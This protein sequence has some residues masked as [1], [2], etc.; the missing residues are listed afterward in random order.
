MCLD[1]PSSGKEWLG[2]ELECPSKKVITKQGRK[3]ADLEH[4]IQQIRDWRAWVTDNLSYARQ[5]KEQNGLGLI[6]ITPRFFGHVIIGR[7]KDYNNKFNELRRQLMRDELITIHS[8]DGFVEYARKRASVFSTISDL[9][10]LIQKQQELIEK[11]KEINRLKEL[12]TEIKHAEELISEN[13]K[14]ISILEQQYHQGLVEF[15]TTLPESLVGKISTLL[16]TDSTV[17]SIIKQVED[18]IPNELPQ[19]LLADYISRIMTKS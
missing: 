1:I 12:V 18:E 13:D 14:T 3:T 2:I 16:K 17:S 19:S 8:W 11:S 4:A 15:G 7:R 9:S 5:N 6:D 10:K